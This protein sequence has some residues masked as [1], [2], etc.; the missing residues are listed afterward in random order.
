MYN[1]VHTYRHC[2][3][4]YTFFSDT[5]F[6]H[7]IRELC[8]FWSPTILNTMVGWWENFL[9]KKKCRQRPA[10]VWLNDAFYIYI[11]QTANTNY[12]C[13]LI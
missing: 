4:W 5:L 11:R 2:S 8:A 1:G 13:V 10:E 9:K 7:S 6:A 3:V 12:V